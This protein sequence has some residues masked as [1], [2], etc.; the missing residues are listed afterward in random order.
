MF[1]YNFNYE[2]KS[3]LRNN[4]IL[5][6]SLLLLCL[7]LFSG[8]NG[9]QKV[10][11]RVADI[12]KVN[13]QV[14]EG[15]SLAVVLLDSLAAGYGVNVSSWRRPDRPT[16]VGAYNP[17]VAAM[18]PAPLALIATGQSDIF[19][20]YVQPSIYGD[21]FA[22][23]LTELSSPVQLL[24]GSFDLSFVLIYLLPLIVIAFTYD[25]LS[26]ERENGSLRLL[27]AQPLSIF[28]WLSQKALIRFFLFECD[29][30]YSYQIDFA[31]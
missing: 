1:Q 9:N 18:P 16:A 13:K 22:L 19:T 10:A 12:E 28:A 8:Y 21:E 17:R 30:R 15:D 14:M 11:K 4:W 2:L 27:A 29:F 7:C 6:V 5:S 20:H 24:F 23:K 3:L 25:L 26:S 31:N